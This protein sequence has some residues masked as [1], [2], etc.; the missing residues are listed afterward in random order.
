MYTTSI[1]QIQ[2]ELREVISAFE[3][4][5]AYKVEFS[6]WDHASQPTMQLYVACRVNNNRVSIHTKAQSIE[7]ALQEI[8]EWYQHIGAPRL[9]MAS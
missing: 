2:Q 6:I 8:I 7:D 3:Q 9:A 1:I 5:E 4:V